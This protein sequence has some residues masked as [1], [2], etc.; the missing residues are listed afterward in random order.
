MQSWQ[1]ANLKFARKGKYAS[2]LANKNMPKLSDRN[3]PK[4][5][6]KEHAKTF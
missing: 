6:D 5:S 3:M 2:E 4:L 1:P